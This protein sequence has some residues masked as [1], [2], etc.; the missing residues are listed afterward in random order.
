MTQD[1]GIGNAA[2]ARLEAGGIATMMSLRQLRGPDAA[3]MVAECGFDGFYVDREHGTYTDAEASA[4]GAAGQ[5]LGLRPAVRVRATA[6]ADIGAALD[7][8]ALCIIVPHV[9]SAGEARRAVQ[10]AR[11]PPRGGRSMMALNPTTRYRSVPGAELARQVDAL[12][13]VVAM[14]ETADGVAAA[15]EIAAV[16]GIDA[17]MMGPND[18]SAELGI[19]GQV[20]H[21]RILEA[22]REAARAA[23]AAGIHFV[24]GGAG[25]PDA[26]ELAALGARIFMGGSDVG[27]MIASGKAAASTL[28][29]QATGTG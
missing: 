15:A 27:Y 14:L 9:T 12:V 29:K 8:G 13:M 24:A 21:P 23:R 11:F 4:T 16:P 26:A 22:Y 6:P 18:L 17:L 19:H 3:M 28:R 5:L 20:R 7:G 10:A 25:G 2:R 1:G